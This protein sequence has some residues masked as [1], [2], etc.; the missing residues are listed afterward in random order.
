MRVCYIKITRRAINN[1]DYLDFGVLLGL[2]IGLLEEV[3]RLSQTESDGYIN[4]WLIQQF[5]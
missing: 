3:L 1:G 4:R 5:R 2:T